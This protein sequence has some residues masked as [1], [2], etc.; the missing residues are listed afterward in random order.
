MPDKAMSMRPD[1][2]ATLAL[3]IGF[4][5]AGTVQADDQANRQVPI[6]KLLPY[7]DLYLQLA[8]TDRDGFRLDYL[9]GVKE[10]QPRPRLTYV[11]GTQR[12]PIQLDRSGKVLNLPDQNL[13]RAGKVEIAG[14]GQSGSITLN[15]EPVVPLAR[16]I[17]A[18]AAANPVQDYAKAIS[19]AGPLSLAIPKLGGLVFKGVPSG[20]VVFGDGR[21]LN[22][23]LEDG[24]PV[25]RPAQ[26]AMRGAATLEFPAVP[27][28]AA[29]TR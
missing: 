16:T 23:P 26:A 25:F 4:G 17:P 29:F 28:K 14:G 9:I 22:L 7:Y 10:G 21:R 12:I 24:N 13:I 19:R 18:T 2:F 20:Q 8:P 3:V 6:K 11:N 5:L 1:F 15:L 27:S